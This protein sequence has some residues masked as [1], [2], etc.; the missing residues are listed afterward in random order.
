MSLYEI[1]DEISVLSAFLRDL[2]QQGELCSPIKEVIMTPIMRRMV[3]L[4]EIICR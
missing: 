2:D 3:Y 1:M 4:M